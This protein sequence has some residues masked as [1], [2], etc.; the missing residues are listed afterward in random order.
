[1]SLNAGAWTLLEGGVLSKFF[2][3]Q[4]TDYVSHTDIPNTCWVNNEWILKNNQT[5]GLT[6]FRKRMVFIESG[7]NI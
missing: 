3:P 4:V 5:C 1:M 7:L 6:I 2:E